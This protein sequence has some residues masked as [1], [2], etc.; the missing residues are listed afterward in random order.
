[1][2]RLYNGATSTV[3]V[4]QLLS[5]QHMHSCCQYNTRTA[6]FLLSVQHT[7]SCTPVSTTHASCTP[8]VSTTHAQLHSYCQYNRRTAALLLSVQHTHSCSP[9]STPICTP[10]LLQKPQDNI[11]CAVH[12]AQ[13]Q[14]T[15]HWHMHGGTINV[16]VWRMNTV[17]VSVQ[18]KGVD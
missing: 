16:C 5:V 6:A 1:M 18:L 4:V 3:T 17:R 2:A 11:R 9:H 12:M 14:C 15:W 10:S 7:H 8:P 13:Q